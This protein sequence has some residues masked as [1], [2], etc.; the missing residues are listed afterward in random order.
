MLL[1]LFLNLLMTQI[2]NGEIPM[3]KLHKNMRNL[4]YGVYIQIFLVVY[5]GFKG[6][7]ITKSVLNVE[8][9]SNDIVIRN[10]Q[11]FIL[12]MI[13]LFFCLNFAPPNHHL[14]IYVLNL[15]YIEYG[16]CYLKK[17][18]KESKETAMILSRQVKKVNVITYMQQQYHCQESNR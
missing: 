4:R 6:G 5:D 17:K 3:K 14:R 8:K 11:D 2:E 13:I 10:F 16:F 9:R 18:Y 7:G 12:L 15:Q 1:H